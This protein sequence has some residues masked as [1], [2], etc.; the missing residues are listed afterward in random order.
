LNAQLRAGHEVFF[1]T[2]HAEVEASLPTDFNA[3][4]DWTIR[5]NGKRRVSSRVA[6]GL[7]DKK[8]ESERLCHS[9][10][11]IGSGSGGRS[12]SNHHREVC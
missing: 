8:T 4:R 6:G 9:A 7:I 3:R 1:F 11:W 2:R 5:Q 10:L 12:G